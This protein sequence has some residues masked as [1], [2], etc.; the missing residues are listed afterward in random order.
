METLSDETLKSI[1]E[2]LFRK[3]NQP[4]FILDDPIC[5]PHLFSQKEDIE[6]AGFLSATLAWG[7]RKSIIK[8]GLKL[9]DCL[10]RMPH[11]FV[12][13]ANEKEWHRLTGFVHR[14]FNDV[15]AKFFLNSLRNI[16]T[17]LG[18]LENVFSKPI[19][20]DDVSTEKGIIHLRKVFFE[21]PFPERTLK[22][23]P[24][25]T[26]TSCAKRICM[27]LRWMVRK[28][29]HGVDFGIWKKIKPSQL[30]CPL[31]VHVATQARNIG[32][33]SRKLNDWKSALYLT[34][35]LR[36]LDPEDPVKYDF[37]LFGMGIHVDK[38]K[39]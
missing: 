25:I 11:Q 18:G 10:D 5:I 33:L 30:V 7:N 34:D 22:H 31:D 9:M 27:F 3:Y 15:D 13:N 38:R 28:D 36:R 37:A 20:V 24:D 1:L 29:D 8:S 32:L 14:T 39:N 26:K 17:K 4:D 35:R 23:I 12:V 2:P 6:I 19:T 16:Y 21:I